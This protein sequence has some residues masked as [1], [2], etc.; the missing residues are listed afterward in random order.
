MVYTGCNIR[1]PGASGKNLAASDL[2]GTGTSTTNLNFT[3]LEMP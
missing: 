3:Q 2:E 1:T